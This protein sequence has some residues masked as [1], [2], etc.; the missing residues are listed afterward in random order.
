MSSYQRMKQ[1]YE[2]EIQ[3]LTSDIVTLVKEDKPA[4]VLAVSMKWRIIIDAGD[5]VWFGKRE[6]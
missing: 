4:E 3:E 1:K 5:I 2:N 6:I